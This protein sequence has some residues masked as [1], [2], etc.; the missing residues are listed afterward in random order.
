MRAPA[1]ILLATAC[2]HGGWSCR[3]AR[4]ASVRR[5]VVVLAAGYPD[6]DEPAFDY[7]RG[8]ASRRSTVPSPKDEAA[9]DEAAALRQGKRRLQSKAVGSNGLPN[10]NRKQPPPSR[11]KVRRSAV[12][13][14][15]LPQDP[16]AEAKERAE[17]FSDPSR[18]INQAV[19]DASLPLRT[20]LLRTRLPAAYQHGQSAAWAVTRPSSA[21]VPPQGAPG[22]SGLLGAPREGPTHWAPSHRLGCSSQ[23]PPKPPIPVALRLTM[24]AYAPKKP[25]YSG[26]MDTQ[27]TLDVVVGALLNAPADGCARTIALLAAY[28]P[29]L[30]FTNAPLLY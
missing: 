21:P 19:R 14:P 5:G 28:A 22:G 7:R 15:R 20:E 2:S 11:P 4:P 1:A 10:T 25:L 6:A 29:L 3:S 9:V 18:R 16:Q 17:A 23:P 30:Y 8:A 24:Q 12:P 26:A 27:H 13:S